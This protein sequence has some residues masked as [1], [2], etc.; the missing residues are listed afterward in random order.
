MKPS[1]P[2]SIVKRSAAVPQPNAVFILLDGISYCEVAEYTEKEFLNAF[3]DWHKETLPTLKK[4]NV[5]FFYR[6]DE[7]LKIFEG[8]PCS[9]A[10]RFSTKKPKSKK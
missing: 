6:T 7:A 4:S 8:L 3:A 10:K 9:C 2:A 1:V 5:R